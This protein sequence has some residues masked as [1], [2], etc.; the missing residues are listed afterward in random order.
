MSAADVRTFRFVL[1]W[2]GAVGEL[3]QGF[4]LSEGYINRPKTQTY[5]V[6]GSVSI[7]RYWW[8]V[9]RI[10]EPDKRGIPTVHVTEDPSGR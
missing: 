10:D 5:E 8:R 3:P 6:G 9:T 4:T 1:T 7:G 2:Q